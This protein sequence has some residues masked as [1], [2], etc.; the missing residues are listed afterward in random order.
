MCIRDRY[1]RRVRGTRVGGMLALR[2]RVAAESAAR[3]RRAALA[4]TRNHGHSALSTDDCITVNFV[5]G[6]EKWAVQAPVG[7]DLLSLCHKEDIDLEGAC[8][9]SIACSTCHVVLVEEVFNSLPEPS[10]EEDDMLDLAWGLTQTSRLGC[11]VI[12]TKDL[13]GMVVK[14]PLMS[15]N[16]Y[17]DGHKPHHH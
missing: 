3:F 12:C 4:Q 8:E 14:I 13:D 17:V 10:E 9:G 15:R 6:E 2:C 11:Q 7:I 5:K 1:Q 16:M